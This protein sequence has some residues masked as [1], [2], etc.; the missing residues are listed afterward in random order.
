[1]LASRRLARRTSATALIAIASLAAGAGVANAGVL[2]ASAPSCDAQALSKPF[3]PWLDVADYTALPGGN[4]EG[5]GAGWSTTGT[6]GV[7][8]GNESFHVGGAADDQSLAL[9]AGGS[10]TSPTI[11]A[12][13]EHPTLRFFAKR[14]STSLLGSLSTLRVDA[15]VETSLGGVLTVPIGVVASGGSWQPT[16]PMAVV[17][18]LLPLLPGEHTPIAFRF[19]AQGGDWS[20]DDVFVDPYGRKP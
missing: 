3:T 18:N 11:C 4:F 7:A 14:R 19:T 17:A 5:D 2:V 6:A 10:A 8:A 9:S 15:L 13:L 12:G 16:L 1:M 20:V